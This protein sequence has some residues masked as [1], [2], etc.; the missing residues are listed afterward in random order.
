MKRPKVITFDIGHTLCFPR[1]E[2][3]IQ[4]LKKHYDVNLKATDLRE[5]DRR[6]R[7]V[8]GRES[9]KAL[10]DLPIPGV[11]VVYSGSLISELLPHRLNET[12]TLVR[13]LKDCMPVQDSWFSVMPEDA[14]PCLEMLQ[15]KGFRLGIISNA[16]GKVIQN[17]TVAGINQYFDFVVDSGLLDFEKPDARIFRHACELAGIKP[18]RLLHIGDSVRSDVLGAMNAGSQAALY[19][20]DFR[21]HQGVLPPHVPHFRSLRAFADSFCPAE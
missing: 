11:S 19:D 1:F 14:I 9:P 16:N 15:A 17:L 4:F 18:D 7:Y 8:N 3:F 6:I 10:K 12:Q 2:D 20:P 5:A 13:F 21:V